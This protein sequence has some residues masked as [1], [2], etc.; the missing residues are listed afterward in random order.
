M[1]ILAGFPWQYEKSMGGEVHLWDGLGCVHDSLW[2]LAVLDR[3]VAIPTLIC[4]D[5]L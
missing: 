5:A 4:S 1:I 3:A 2:F